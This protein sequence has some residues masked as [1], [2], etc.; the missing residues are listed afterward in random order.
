[1]SAAAQL[2]VQITGWTLIHFVW[3]G[4][5]AGLALAGLLRRMRRAD[6]SARYAAS[7]LA[8]LLMALMPPVTALWLAGTWPADKPAGQDGGPDAPAAAAQGGDMGVTQELSMDRT[9]KDESGQL[10]ERYSTSRRIVFRSGGELSGG[11]G[12]PWFSPQR[13]MAWLVAGW[14]AG[15]ALLSV[16][17]AAGLVRVRRLIARYAEPATVELED[18]LRRLV[19]RLR[20]SRPVRVLVSRAA[21]VPMVVGWLRPVILVPLSSLMGLT[22]LQLEAV[23]AHELAHIRRHDYLA[24]LFQTIVETVLFYHPAVW[25][26]SARIRAERENCCDDFGAAVHGNARA[27]ARALVVLE[28]L[29][30]TTA[31]PAG[32]ALSATGGPLLQRVRRL[33]R[34]GS[35][36]PCGAARWLAGVLAILALALFAIS[37]Q[38][39]LRGHASTSEAAQGPMPPSAEVEIRAGDFAGRSGV[40]LSHKTTTGIPVQ[41]A[42]APAITQTAIQAAPV[43]SSRIRIVNCRTFDEAELVFHLLD[44]AGYP[45]VQI[46]AEDQGYVVYVKSLTPGSELRRRPKPGNESLPNDDAQAGSQETVVPERQDYPMAA[47]TAHPITAGNG[48]SSERW[49]IRVM[50]NIPEKGTAYSLREQLKKD[51]V[52]PVD[53]L[54]RNQTYTVCGTGETVRMPLDVEQQDRKYTVMAGDFPS[55]RA[56]QQA[57]AA[58]KTPGGYRPEGVQ[59]IAPKTRDGGSVRVGEFRRIWRVFIDSFGKSDFAEQGKERMLTEDGYAGVEIQREGNQF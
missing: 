58:L 15:V 49:R 40:G 53:V 31:R 12:A 13:W 35:D 16:R 3:Q 24:N 20:M 50:S 33:V 44:D 52:A 23:L 42:S 14:L 38:M 19:R 28:E 2:W 25:W 45:G 8:L 22:P 37:M 21:D 51:G 59:K 6:A 5:L 46:A 34:A 41:S 54:E 29:R 32:A 18:M 47:R 1:M 4:A 17:L 26:V 30:K 11:T 9:Y 57:L 56:A 43:R 55:E 36:D 27:Y 48:P 7:C 10:T 39:P